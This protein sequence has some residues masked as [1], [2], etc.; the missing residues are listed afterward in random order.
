MPNL[1][2]KNV[3]NSK[4]TKLHDSRNIYLK[5]RL[6][7]YTNYLVLFLKI[8]LLTIILLFL[9]TNLFSN[10]K[11]DFKV[12]TNKFIAEYGFVLKNIILQGQKN[13]N[14]RNVVDSLSNNPKDSI[15]SLDIKELK[16]SLTENTWIKSAIVERRLPDTLYIAL[17]EREPIAIWQYNG[18]LFLIDNFGEPIF[19]DNLAKFSNLLLVVGEDANLYASGLIN[20]LRKEYHLAQR[21]SSAVR[22]GG[23]RWNLIMDENIEVKMPEDDFPKA[24]NFLKKMHKAGKLFNNKIRVLDLRNHEKYFIEHK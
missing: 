18:K 4:P 17:F 14:I 11:R 1:S 12:I 24:Y 15:F 3:K 7:F 16:K 6:F 19:E 20:D 13:S 23:R 22:Y 21:I 2:N 5:R 9:F 8:A 10:Y